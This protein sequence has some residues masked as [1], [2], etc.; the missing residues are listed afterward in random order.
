[1]FSVRRI[2]KQTNLKEFDGLYLWRVFFLMKRTLSACSPTDPFTALEP[3]GQDIGELYLV[4][5]RLATD[6]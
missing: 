6:F 3:E 2:N 4:Q 5:E 1:M